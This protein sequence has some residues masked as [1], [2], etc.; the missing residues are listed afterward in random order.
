VKT[1][2]FCESVEDSEHKL[3][4]CSRCRLVA[5]CSKACQVAHWKNGHKQACI[6]VQDRKPDSSINTWNE[7][8]EVKNKT[9]DVICVICL[10]TLK[11]SSTCTLPCT[12]SFHSRCVSNLRSQAAS[13]VC[14]LCRTDLP[15]GPEQAY[16]EC[17]KLFHATEV[18][19]P[20][21]TSNKESEDAMR[22][23]FRLGNCAAEEGHV[24]AQRFVGYCYREGLV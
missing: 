17:V 22:E 16:I 15:P 7:T 24:N 11:E 4:A 3:Q 1:C 2:G 13:Q 18:E 12:H 5:Y 10:E 9:A 20:N 6:A 21:K 19:A 14:P 23:S 8:Q